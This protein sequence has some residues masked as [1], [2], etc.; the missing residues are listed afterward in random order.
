VTAD[1][2]LSQDEL[3]KELL[4]RAKDRGLDYAI[5]VRRVGGGGAA[6]SF[7]KAAMKMAQQGGQGGNSLAEVYK[8]TP[9]GHEELV[10]G[11]ELTEMTPAAFKDIVAVGDSST[12]YTDEFVPRIGALFSMGI[13]GSSD[14]PVVS[15]VVPALLFDD[16]SLAQNQGPF[17]NPPIS[18]SP[19][20]K[21]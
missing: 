1:K 9:D 14:E 5:V 4:R 20:A 17:P 18:P 7:M 8:L 19:L 21:Q 11:I 15:C 6:A 12:V 3:R 10:R 16:V 13:S 2:S